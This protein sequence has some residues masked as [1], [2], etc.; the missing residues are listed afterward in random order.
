MNLSE[1]YDSTLIR[2]NLMMGFKLPTNLICKILFFLS[3]LKS[4]SL[5]QQFYYFSSSFTFSFN[6]FYFISNRTSSTVE[7]HYERFSQN[8]IKL[9]CNNA[10]TMFHV[11]YTFALKFNNISQFLSKYTPCILFFFFSLLNSIHLF[12][13][14]SVELVLHYDTNFM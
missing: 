8:F 7:L 11:W 5:R 6:F 1:N 3:L 10:H 4:L 2:M 9:L 14:W 13:R 12:P